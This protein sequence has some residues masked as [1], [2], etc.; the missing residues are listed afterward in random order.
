MSDLNA[1]DYKELFKFISTIETNIQNWTYV[2][3]NADYLDKKEI[4]NA[5]AQVLDNIEPLVAGLR[6]GLEMQALTV[7]NVEDLI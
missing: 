3:V 4:Q 1:D 5:L 2:R 7:L 6:L